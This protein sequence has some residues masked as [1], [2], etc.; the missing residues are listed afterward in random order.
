MLDDLLLRVV[1]TD[2]IAPKI[3]IFLGK[4]EIQ[5]EMKRLLMALAK[6]ANRFIPSESGD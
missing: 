2:E 5:P 4:G 1:E 3:L 6:G